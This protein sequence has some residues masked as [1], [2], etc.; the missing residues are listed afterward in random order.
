MSEKILSTFRYRRLLDILSL[1]VIFFL[2]AVPRAIDLDRFVTPDEP[3]W[4][5]RS[6]NFLTA[7]VQKDF[8]H[9]FQREHPGVTIMWAG[10]AGF[11]LRYP[12]FAKIGPGQIDRIGDFHRYLDNNGMDSIVALESGRMFS[13]LGIAA[14]LLLAFW[15]ARKVFGM[16]VALLGFLFVAINPFSIALARLLHLDSMVSS[17]MLLSLLALMTYLYRGRRFID[18]VVSAIAAGLSW[19]TK[20]PALFLLPFF[21]LLILVELI[22][23]WRGEKNSFKSTS[24][25]T[26]KPLM[27]W[28]GIAMVTFTIF[29]PAMWVDPLNTI[30]KIF[31]Q[32]IFYASEGHESN[33]FFDGRVYQ[34]GVQNGWFY[35]I[36]YLWRATPMTVLGLLLFMFAFILPRK[37]R[38][39]QD[40]QN[41]ALVLVLFIVLYTT[42]M[43]LGAKKFDRYLLPIFAPLDILAAV[44]WVTILTATYQ[45]LREK[46]GQSPYLRYFMIASGVLFTTAFSWQ[47]WGVMQTA[48][49]YLSYYNPLLGGSER[50]PEVMMIGW[51]EGLDQAARYLNQSTEAGKLRV[52]SW[53][54]DGPFSYFFNGTTLLEEF[55]AIPADLPKVDYIV[56][57]FHQLQRQLPSEEFLAF[58]D[59][60]TLEHVIR[61][62]NIPYAYIYRMY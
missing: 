2:L 47:S 50:A 46:L 59:Q 3:K 22:R 29:F 31:V 54:Y 4:L 24:W 20:S 35:P 23:S 11:F 43:T 37:I 8:K 18:L 13:V 51:G 52:M 33:I 42:F 40:L 5:H 53:Y 44:G 32:A 39:K 61:I 14:S 45:I 1:V 15:Y 9:T 16:G 62:G 56:I 55:P 48:P 30:N 27:I 25:R 57:Y 7:L 60:Q 26:I 41:S 38:F 36:N 49:Y 28:S 10:A 6:A 17:L 19:L 12:Q 58:I 34:G 21:G